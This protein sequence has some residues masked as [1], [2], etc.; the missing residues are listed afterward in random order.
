MEITEDRLEFADDLALER[1]VHPENAVGRWVLRTHRDFEELAIEARGPR[2]EAARALEAGRHSEKVSESADY[3][4]TSFWESWRS[5]ICE[6]RCMTFILLDH[7]RAVLSR[8]R[9]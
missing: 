6:M 5:I 2:G 7:F 1:N 3:R 4:F 9:V 8:A